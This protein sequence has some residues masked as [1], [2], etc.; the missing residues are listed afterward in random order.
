MRESSRGGP[1]LLEEQVQ[2]E[3]GATREG[4]DC[5]EGGVGHVCI[6]FPLRPTRKWHPRCPG[7]EAISVRD[8]DRLGVDPELGPEVIP[9]YGDEVGR[10][11]LGAHPAV[12][13]L[14]HRDDPEFAHGIGNTVEI[15]VEPG[16]LQPEVQT[17]LVRDLIRAI[18]VQLVH[19]AV[20]V[21]IDIVVTDLEDGH[22]GLICGADEARFTG[23]A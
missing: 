23:S 17:N 4:H 7:E 19:K 1:S 22:A 12:G 13:L 9:D 11:R 5:V 16:L 8:L 15:T 20:P 21:V 10:V 6:P 3:R 18:R 2:V 14:N